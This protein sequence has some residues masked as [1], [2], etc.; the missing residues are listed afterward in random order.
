MLNNSGRFLI[1][2][3]T[4]FYNITTI[5]FMTLILMAVSVVP[6]FLGSLIIGF[7]LIGEFFFHISSKGSRDF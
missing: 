2:D 6:T 5:I 4:D 1:M 7:L 3:L